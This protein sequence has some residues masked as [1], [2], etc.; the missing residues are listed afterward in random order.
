MEEKTIIDLLKTMAFQSPGLVAA[1]ALAWMFTKHLTKRQEFEKEMHTEHID[2]R[3]Q[4]REAMNENARAL[5]AFTNEIQRNMAEVYR[6][7]ESNNNLTQ[8]LS[9]TNL[10]ELLTRARERQGETKDKRD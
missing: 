6:N 7:T 1:L 5:R 2:E 8:T 10:K 4:C 3:T 9:H